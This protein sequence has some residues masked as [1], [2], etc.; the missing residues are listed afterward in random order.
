MQE[1]ATSLK[2]NKLGFVHAFAG[3]VKQTAN[4]GGF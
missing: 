2:K 3:F 4:I 1:Q